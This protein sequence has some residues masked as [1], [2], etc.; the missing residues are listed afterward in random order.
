MDCRAS[1]RPASSLKPVELGAQAQYRS[2]LSHFLERSFT[3][4]AADTGDGVGQHGHL[5]ACAS[6]IERGCP[7]TIVRREAADVQLGDA[8]LTKLGSERPAIVGRSLER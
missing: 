4:L 2:S 3:A 7:H 6:R 1:G 5:K 8:T